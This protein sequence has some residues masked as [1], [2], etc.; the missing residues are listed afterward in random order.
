M[1]ETLEREVVIAEEMN[2][3]NTHKPSLLGGYW[4]VRVAIDE[5]KCARFATSKMGELDRKACE[6]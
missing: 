6:E 4:C 5:I 2:C 3:F 1:A